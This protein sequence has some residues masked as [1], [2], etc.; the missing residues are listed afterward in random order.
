MSFSERFIIGN[1]VSSSVSPVTGPLR[2]LL[3]AGG[4]GTRLRPLTM[5]IPKCLVSVG[6][7][8][9]L[10]RWLRT[11]EGAGCESALINTHYLAEQVEDFLRNRKSSKM[12]IDTIH[13]PVLLGTA[14][15]LLANQDFFLNS[16][17]LLIHA[18][19]V[20]TDRLDGLLSAHK[21]RPTECLLT[22]LTFYTDSPQSC[23]IVSLDR[24]NVVVGFHEKVK[25][26]PG[27]CANGAIYVFDE[28]L[29][30]EMNG[31]T[32]SPND[33]STEVIP[34]LM[35]R[36]KTWHTKLPYLDIGTPDALALA[37]VILSVK[38]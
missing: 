6:G 19:N 29:L 15:T 21:S 12:R 25:D 3:L 16:T 31:F 34:L 26:P 9:L 1:S 20:M 14:G 35:G 38:E 33:F 30:K 22:M 32:D 8:P 18:D 37:Q 5:K 28:Q 23:G 24:N 36:I 4:L 11:L 2:A 7:E 27:K 10:E 17:G 13:E